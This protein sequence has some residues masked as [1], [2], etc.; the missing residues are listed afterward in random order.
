MVDGNHRILE[1]GEIEVG[2]QRTRSVSASLPGTCCSF[3]HSVNRPERIPSPGPVLSTGKRVVS[4]A[5]EVVSSWSFHSTK[6]TWLFTARRWPTSPAL[7]PPT[8]HLL[9]HSEPQV[10]LP[11]SVTAVT[12]LWTVLTHTPALVPGAQLSCCSSRSLCP[13]PTPQG[14][15]CHSFLG[16]PTLCTQLSSRASPTALEFFAY[17]SPSPIGLP[18]APGRGPAHRGPQ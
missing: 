16:P 1:N 8:R 18:P 12:S 3:I 9:H 5:G 4:K 6:F 11:T 10:F 17:Q 13:L 7:S 15:A 14:T 2:R